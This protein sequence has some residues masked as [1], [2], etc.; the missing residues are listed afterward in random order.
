MRTAASR[1]GPTA[2]VPIDTWQLFTSSVSVTFVVSSGAPGGSTSRGPCGLAPP[3]GFP[4][5]DDA[6]PGKNSISLFCLN[7]PRPLHR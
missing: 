5:L 6:M 2:T 3:P 7:L 4:A 1:Y